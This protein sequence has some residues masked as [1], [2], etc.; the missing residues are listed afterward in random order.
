[1]PL[2]KEVILEFPNIGYRRV[3]A[4]LER[5][6]IVTQHRV[7]DAHASCGSQWCCSRIDDDVS[8][9]YPLPKVLSTEEHCNEKIF[10]PI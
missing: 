4:E 9:L 7:R 10:D 3:H 2:L 5:K 8:K 6:K 1:M